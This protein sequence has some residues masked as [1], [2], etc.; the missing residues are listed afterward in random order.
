VQLDGDMEF[1]ITASDLDEL[2]TPTDSFPS[3]ELDKFDEMGEEEDEDVPVLTSGEHPSVATPTGEYDMS[4]I[5]DLIQG[6]SG[7]TAIIPEIPDDDD[8]DSTAEVDNEVTVFDVDFAEEPEFEDDPGPNY[9]MGGTAELPVMDD[10]DDFELDL[11]VEPAAA[12]ESEENEPSVV[13]QLVTSVSED[14]MEGDDEEPQLVSEIMPAISDDML[15]R[16]IVQDASAFALDAADVLDEGDE[17]ETMLD[18]AKAYLDMGDSDSASSALE[19]IIAAGNDRQRQ[20][21][22]ELLHKIS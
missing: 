6:G 10:V 8:L 5:Q 19:E 18:L 7:E 9:N 14:M 22:Q 11:E 4:R 17:V 13:S 1:D 2:G 3:A 20:E 21:A 16:T 12:D 15:D